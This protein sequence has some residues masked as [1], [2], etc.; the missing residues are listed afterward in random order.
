MTTTTL[1]AHSTPNSDEELI[2]AIDIGATRIRVMAGHAAGDGTLRFAGYGE[3]AAAGLRKGAVAELDR[4][5]AAIH[6]AVEQAERAAN[7][8]IESA[9]VAVGGAHVR[10]INSRGG[11]LLGSRARDVGREDVRNAVDHARS[12]QLPPDRQVL[13]LLPKQFILDEQEGIQDPIGMT[14]TQLEADLHLVTSSISATQSLITAVNKA[15]MTVADTVFEAVAA[16]ESLSGM[17]ESERILGCAVVDIGAAS[18]NVIAYNDGGV[19]HTASLAIGG[20]HFTSDIAMGL[21]T[22]LPD[23]E[24]LKCIYG[25]AVVVRVPAENDIEVPSGNISPRIVS[26]RY[27]AEIIEPRTRELFELV[28]DSLRTAGVLDSL[29]AGVF[30]TGGG[31]RLAGIEEICEQVLRCA[32]RIEAADPILRMPDDLVMPETTTVTG[33]LAYAHRTRNAKQS[34]ERGLKAKLRQLLAGA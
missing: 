32:V 30:L 1:R 8:E 9:V 3:S 12:V 7:E 2:C 4:L 5:V 27:L 21:R 15:G 17:T 16:A 11:I 23:A 29:G 14:G 10:G 6:S 26:Q 19:I 33:L 13:H 25:C 24:R 31:A 34:S 20:D 18:T 22:P 28:R